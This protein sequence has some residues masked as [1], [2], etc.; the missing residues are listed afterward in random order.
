M[1]PKFALSA[2]PAGIAVLSLCASPLAAAELPIPLPQVDTSVDSAWMPGDDTAANHRWYRYRR[3]RVDAG[4]VL[5]G[6]LILG[7]I[8][9]IASAANR[10]RDTRYP[11]RSYPDPRY[12]GGD[13]RDEGARGLDRAVSICSA[14]IERD[15]RIDRIDGVTRSAGGWRVTGSLYN[16]D[17]F[18]CSIGAD[19]RV[20]NI[21]IDGRAEPY[22]S[23]ENDGVDYDAGADDQWDDDVYSADRAR[24]EGQSADGSDGAQVEY[25]GGPVADEV[26]PS[27]TI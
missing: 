8:A 12:R 11:D 5:A 2:I 25:P 3:N 19:G 13:W 17:G 4:D 7:G 23:S 26:D 15:A 24:I 22:R 27:E 16:G 18:S 14:E 6:V 9:A 10:N 1:T 20:Q 21:D